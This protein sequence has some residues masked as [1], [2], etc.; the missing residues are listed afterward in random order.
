MDFVLGPVDVCARVCA[1]DAAGGREGGVGSLR[2]GYG[3]GEAEAKS[4][5]TEVL[6]T[7]QENNANSMKKS[8][9]SRQ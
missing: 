1:K 7:Q 9:G 5:T 6:Q 4:Q 2:R 3:R 8:P